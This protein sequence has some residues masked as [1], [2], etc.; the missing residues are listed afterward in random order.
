MKGWRNI[1]SRNDLGIY[2]LPMES[3]PYVS[4]V[5]WMADG[6]IIQSERFECFDVK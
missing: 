3:I 6:R 5:V 1:V 4:L 2:A